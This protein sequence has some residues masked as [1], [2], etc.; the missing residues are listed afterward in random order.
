MHR[1]SSQAI[2]GKKIFTASS[3]FDDMVILDKVNGKNITQVITNAVLVNKDQTV[4]GQI[5]FKQG[6][7]VDNDMYING[8]IEM[9]GKIDG[10]NITA[11]DGEI[12]KVHGR[13]DLVGNKVSIEGILGIESFNTYGLIN[14][15]NINTDLVT[16]TT[17]QEIKG[18]CIVYS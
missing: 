15:I 12:L 5:T 3:I 2:T 14:N 7:V 8:D 18:K 4:D 16:K 6:M 13:Q 9:T 10:I 1:I 17:V 11:F